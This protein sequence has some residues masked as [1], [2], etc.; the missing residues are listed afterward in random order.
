MF[1]VLRYFSVKNVQVYPQKKNI[2]SPYAHKIVSKQSA[3]ITH[4]R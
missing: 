4:G 1:K 2:D 3:R